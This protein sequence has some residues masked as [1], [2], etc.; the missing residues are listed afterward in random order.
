MGLHFESGEPIDYANL[1]QF[2][3]A[4]S[5][6]E[7][8][9]H[10]KI[11][12]A[13]SKNFPAI[14]YQK[15]SLSEL[16]KILK[17]T[18]AN[19]GNSS[20]DPHGKKIDSKIAR[21][22]QDILKEL[23]HVESKR[24]VFQTVA[25][26]ADPRQARTRIQKAIA[27]ENS[28]LKP[29]D[30]FSINPVYLVPQA[31]GV[32][33]HEAAEL[34]TRAH[35]VAGWLGAPFAIVPSVATTLAGK[36]KI[37]ETRL[38]EHIQE[39]S[40]VVQ[41][42]VERSV[43]VSEVFKDPHYTKQLLSRLDVADTQKKAI[44]QALLG[45][46]DLH[47]GNA[48][49]TPATNLQFLKCEEE[50]NWEYQTKSGEWKKVANF[51][52]LVTLKLK[53]VISSDTKVRSTAT[54]YDKEQKKEIAKEKERLIQDDPD[55]QK[56][57]N[58]EWQLALF[59]N[60]AT[61]G[62]GR[63]P[64]IGDH[65]NFQVVHGHAA[66]P[67]ESFLLGLDVSHE[68]LTAEVQE[69]ILQLQERRPFLEKAAF[70]GDQA[71]W[72]RFSEGTKEALHQLFQ[73]AQFF[74]PADIAK[75]GSKEK[76]LAKLPKALLEQII[77][78]LQPSHGKPLTLTEDLKKLLAKSLFPRMDPTEA[79]AFLERVD[80]SIAYVKTANPPTVSGLNGAMFPYFDPFIDLLSQLEAREKS[81]NTTPS[82][83]PDLQKIKKDILLNS[84]GF[85]GYRYIFASC[86]DILHAALTKGLFEGGEKNP[87]YLELSQ[88]IAEV[89]DRKVS[90]P[91][92]LDDSAPL[93][94]K[95]QKTM[96][97]SYYKLDSS[98]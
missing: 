69:W 41:S 75:G 48:L 27:S 68:P 53:G 93:P 73:E 90:S 28:P 42:L 11:L 66:L 59:D 57:L 33:K 97:D 96:D 30:V 40:G 85:Q 9:K 55:V 47:Q 8:R 16:K 67:T 89:R 71:L 91:S 80:R 52:E 65:N 24:E 86:S 46:W 78:D 92:Y 64:S 25:A 19:I 13:I 20:S 23:A 76:L 88:A 45:A 94:V 10:L 70:E 18:V 35:E 50:K 87:K 43:K 3:A 7:K 61:L 1:Q 32:F 21:T 98:S 84:K 12:R 44:V 2:S 34:D 83:S 31:E 4:G 29:L 38:G 15:K 95:D 79:T 14:A 36:K 77:Q 63:S 17:Q 54:V 72:R 74:Y 56:A 37:L 6:A 62:G 82:Q 51:L 5:D 39:A 26:C 58:V 49:L 22:A 81:M 60:E